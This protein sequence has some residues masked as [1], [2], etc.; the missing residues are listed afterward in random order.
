MYF[1]TTSVS[2]LSALAGITIAASTVGP[3]TAHRDLPAGIT[4]GSQFASPDSPLR[5]P[6]PAISWANYAIFTCD[7]PVQWYEAIVDEGQLLH[8][9]V[10]VPE[11]EV[12]VYPHLIQ[13]QG[14]RIVL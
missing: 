3:A 1:H 10:T 11:I 5:I 9:T 4:C 7:D 8:H 12:S 13:C 2:T 6:N 14:C